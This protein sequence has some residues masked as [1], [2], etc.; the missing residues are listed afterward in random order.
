M[1]RRLSS[2]VTLIELTAILLIF[3]LASVVILGLFTAAYQK[4]VQARYLNDAMITARDL[5][6]RLYG[7]DVFEEAI[8]EIG[9][10]GQSG[11]YT[12]DLDDGMTLTLT[13]ADEQ[14]EV[15]RLVSGMISVYTEGKQVYELPVSHYYNKEVIHP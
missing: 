8:D 11:S 2:H 1:K 15:G 14:T 7:A 3:M 5:A 9:F 4:S 13:A 12:L 10:E 6:A